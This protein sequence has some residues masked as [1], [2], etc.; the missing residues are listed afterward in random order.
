MA[1]NIVYVNNMCISSIYIALHRFI[2]HISKTQITIFNLIFKHEIM[3]LTIKK[4]TNV[5]KVKTTNGKTIQFFS[6]VN[7]VPGKLINISE[8]EITVNIL[9]REFILK[10]PIDFTGQD[11]K[12]ILVVIHPEHIIL[13][14]GSKLI[15][16]ILKTTFKGSR[17]IID[18]SYKDLVL[19]TELSSKD[20]PDSESIHF[21]LL[22]E[23]LYCLNEI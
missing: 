13:D 6:N 17:T 7:L 19:S 21:N 2:N 22:T 10:K 8:D 20:I 15:G 4:P 11:H 9:E 14:D 12:D 18:F 1:N 23:Y 16:K 3:E 5:K